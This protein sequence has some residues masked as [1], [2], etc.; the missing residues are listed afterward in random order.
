MRGFVLGSG[1]ALDDA[2]HALGGDAVGVVFAFDQDEAPVAAV[3][4]VERENGMGGGAAAREGVEDYVGFVR[5][6]IGGV[7]LRFVTDPAI[8]NKSITKYG[9]F[10]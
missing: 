1:D 4:L 9:D 5:T 8:C 6:S 2:A 3:L 10:G 7:M